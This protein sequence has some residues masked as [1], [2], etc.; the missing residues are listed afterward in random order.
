MNVDSVVSC[1]GGGSPGGSIVMVA[2]DPVADQFSGIPGSSTWSLF[3][4][5]AQ[6][7]RALSTHLSTFFYA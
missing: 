4:H 5:L 1:L 3:L 7:F 2:A 6:Q